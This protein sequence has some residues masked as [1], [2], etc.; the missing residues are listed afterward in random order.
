MSDWL[1]RYVGVPFVDGG[2]DFKGWDCWGLVRAAFRAER[3]IELPSYGEIS[4]L[5]LVRVAKQIAN[6]TAFGVGPWIETL[7]PSSFDVAVMFRRRLAVHVG[8]MID[9][10]RLLHVIENRQTLVLP[11]GHPLFKMLPRVQFFRHK[12]LAR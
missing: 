8:L 11:L 5:D 6:D 3:G 10:H 7:H 2:R 12:E 1:A 4:A 9:H